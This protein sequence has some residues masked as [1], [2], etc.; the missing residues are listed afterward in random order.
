MNLQEFNFEFDPEQFVTLVRNVIIEFVNFFSEAPLFAQVLMGIGIF[1]SVALSIILVYYIGKGLYLLIK[2]ICKG[3]YKLGNKIYHFIERKIEEHT[4][5]YYNQPYNTTE[6]LRNGESS[7]SS[8]FSKNKK[9]VVKNPQN[10]KFCS[11]CGTP[12]SNK[13]LSILTS[14]GRAFCENCGIVQEIAQNSSKIEI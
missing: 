7:D 1:A 6:K 10:V 4:R 12:L 13:V 3:L 8:M 11:F 2:K 9:I 5:T 14:D